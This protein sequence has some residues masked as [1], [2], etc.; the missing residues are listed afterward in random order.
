MRLLPYLL[1]PIAIAIFWHKRRLPHP[2]LSYLLCIVI[3][4]VYAFGIVTLDN[5]LHP[6]PPGPACN[7]PQMAFL[8][9]HVVLL[10]VPLLVQWMVSKTLRFIEKSE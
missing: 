3:L 2:G 10:P 4:E 7:T 8:V 5:F 6:A 1:I 9:F